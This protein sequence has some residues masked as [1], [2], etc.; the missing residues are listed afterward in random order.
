MGPETAWTIRMKLAA[1]LLLASRTSS[2]VRVKVYASLTS[3][4]V[5]VTRTVRMAQMN[6]SIVLG[7]HAQAIK[8]HAPMV[9]VSQTNT[10]ATTSETAQMERT[11]KTANTQHVN[12]SLAPTEL[13]ITAVRNVMGK[14]TAETSLMKTIALRYVHTT[15]SSVTMGCASLMLTSATITL[16]VKTAVMNIL[17]P[18]RPAEA[19]SSLATAATALVKTWFVMERMTVRITAMKTDAKAVVTMFVNATQENGLVQNLENAS[20]L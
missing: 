19:T 20:Q 17:A 16:I 12:S 13:A 4:S 9:N 14:L 1:L 5:T 3:G 10:G 15:S 6:I 7:E 11:R 8:L 18:M 2:Y